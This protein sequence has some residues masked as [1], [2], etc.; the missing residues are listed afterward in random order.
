MEK[1]C[2]VLTPFQKLQKLLEGENYV[3]G[4][5]MIPRISNLRNGLENAADRYFPPADMAE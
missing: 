4:G 2:I 1:V 3:T 5:L